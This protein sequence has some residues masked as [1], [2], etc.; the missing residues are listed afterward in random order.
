[1]YEGVCVCVVL[2]AKIRLI[3][4]E[5]TARNLTCVCGL[6]E[7]FSSRRLFLMAFVSRFLGAFFIVRC[8]GLAARHFRIYE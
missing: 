4:K 6:P 1:M 2:A 8:L 5:R 7:S 3:A